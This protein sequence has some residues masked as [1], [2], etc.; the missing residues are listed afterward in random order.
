MES[1]SAGVAIRRCFCLAAR[2][3]GSGNAAVAVDLISADFSEWAPTF[4]SPAA[5]SSAIAWE[6]FP[7]SFAPVSEPAAARGAVCE[8]SLDG[9][10][11]AAD[12]FTPEA[13]P[14]GLGAVW[15]L[16]PFGGCAL[17]SEIVPPGA[18]A[19][20]SWVFAGEDVCRRAQTFC[21]CDFTS[22]CHFRAARAATRISTSATV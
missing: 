9:S 17:G 4:L 15:E 6:G 12:V 16:V 3:R 10:F 2:V 7:A 11:A 18:G 14:E 19:A 13:L 20:V 5:L 22:V 1:S 8:A 21:V